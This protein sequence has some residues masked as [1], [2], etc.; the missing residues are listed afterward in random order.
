M[1]YAGDH[2][3]RNENK[4]SIGTIR[5]IF[6]DSSRK[7]VRA[8]QWRDPTPDA[9]FVVCATDRYDLATL[10]GLT[11]FYPTNQEDGHNQIERMVTLRQGQRSFRNSLMAAYERRCAITAC[12]IDEV[13]E[14]AHISPYMGEHTNHVTNGLLLRADMHTLFDCGL[15]KVDPD[16]RIIAASHVRDA[17]KLPD[18]IRPSKNIEAHPNC[19]ALKLKMGLPAR[20]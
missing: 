19:E 1:G 5:L 8:V 7:H 12:E 11:P 4:F 15:I 9:K 2:Q 13:L 3:E 17:Y 18:A 14:A 16:L 6:T 20:K 10:A